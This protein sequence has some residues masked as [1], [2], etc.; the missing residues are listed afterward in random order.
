MEHHATT[1]IDI[2]F[3]LKTREARAAL[4]ATTETAVRNDDL[5]F[6]INKVLRQV[7]AHHTE[8][9]QKSLKAKSRKE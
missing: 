6:E 8:R 9:A 7:S 4:A 5:P 2:L 3:D 1:K